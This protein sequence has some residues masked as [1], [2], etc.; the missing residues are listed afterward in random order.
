MLA[1]HRGVVMTLFLSVPCS[2]RVHGIWRYMAPV[3]NRHEPR[4]HVA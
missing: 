2:R 4:C 3:R 1:L